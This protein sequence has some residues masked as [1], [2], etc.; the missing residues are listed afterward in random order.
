MA[1]AQLDRTPDRRPAP[2]PRRWRALALLCMAFFMVILDG[3]VVT[4]ALPSIGRDLGFAAGNLQWVVSGYALTFGGLLLLG[5]RAADLLGQR[6]V[7]MGGVALFT[8]ASLLCGLAWSEEALIGARALQGAGAAVMTPSA[9]SILMTTFAEGG[10]RNKALGVWGAVGGVGAAAGWLIGGPLTDGPGWEWIFYMNVPVGLAL[11]ALS[12]GLLRE[13]G[14]EP[15][16][17]S[18]DPAGALSVTAALFLLVYALVETPDRGWTSTETISLVAASAALIALFVA[19]EARSKAPLV[20]L[21][22]FRSPVLVGANGAMVLFGAVAW[23]MP[24]VLTLYAQQVLGYSPLEFGAT[25]VVMPVTAIVSSMVGQGL[26]T[27]FGARPVAI[28]GMALLALAAVLFTQ[29]SVPGSYFG[30]LFPGL[31]ALG[32]GIG[33]AV[34]AVSVATLAGVADR[35][36]GLASGLNSTSQQLGAAIGTAVVSMVAVSRTED[37]LGSTDRLL[38]LTEGFQSA[39]VACV[40]FALIGLAAAL[41]LLGPTRPA[42]VD[43]AEPAPEP[44]GG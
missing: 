2:D 4:L 24:F 7:F 34:V 5:G 37:L 41:L 8:F 15:S 43:Q 6:G 9:L 3:A 28:A 39:F 30:D 31:I 33:L 13:N 22:I 10:E 21:R 14:G 23:G 42:A 25:F 1:T 44:A 27:R 16:R 20:P 19:I 35:E 17:R 11:L 18:F 40:T 29:V 12:R 26:V 36:A 38:A 32:L